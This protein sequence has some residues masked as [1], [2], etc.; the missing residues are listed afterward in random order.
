MRKRKP[1]RPSSNAHIENSAEQRVV[2]GNLFA[3]L[4]S[5]A[6]VVAAAL[7]AEFFIRARRRFSIKLGGNR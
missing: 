7:F 1:L 2:R 6:G 3:A 4:Y 5:A